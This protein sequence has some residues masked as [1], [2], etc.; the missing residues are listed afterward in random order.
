LLIDA[1]DKRSFPTRGRGDIS[2]PI[3]RPSKVA[4]HSGV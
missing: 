1:S 4:P 2:I 3:V